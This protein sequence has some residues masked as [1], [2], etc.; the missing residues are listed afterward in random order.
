MDAKCVSRI[1]TLIQLRIVKSTLDRRK[2]T[3][4]DTTI[5]KPIAAYEL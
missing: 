1:Q 5:K 2:Y 3:S 4:K